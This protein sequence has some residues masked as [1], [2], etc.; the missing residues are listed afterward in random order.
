MNPS[1]TYVKDKK[2]AVKTVKELLYKLS[3]S[4]TLLFLSGGSTPKDLYINLAKEKKLKIATVALV[5]E[6]FGLKMH[7]NSNEKMI[8]ETGLFDY[9]KSSKIQIHKI[10]K[11]SD[12]NQTTKDY[13][14]TVSGLFKTYK[15][16]IAI[17]GIGQ[18]GHTAG[19]PA[20]VK[21]QKSRINNQELVT[22]VD[23]FP[24]EFSKRITLTFKALEQMDKII[25]LVF[26]KEKKNALKQMFKKG[27][28][29]EIPA[30]FFLKDGIAEKTILITDQKV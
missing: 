13:E 26:G 23:D 22:D 20:V 7:E 17:L 30:R 25:V 16:K 27:L 2:E 21:N 11:G 8:E 4:K 19:L 28:I 29:E 12:I 9:L 10:L 3:S 24:G 18:D 15:N 5:D 1:I 14:K 6:R